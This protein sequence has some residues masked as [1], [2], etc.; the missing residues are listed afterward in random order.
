M[1]RFILILLSLMLSSSF[2]LS[3]NAEVKVVV[4]ESSYVMEDNDSKLDAR[5]RW[6]QA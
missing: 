6:E 4:A 5:L 1:K 2:M 3:A